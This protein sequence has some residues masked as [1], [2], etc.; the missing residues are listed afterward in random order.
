[1]TSAKMCILRFLINWKKILNCHVIAMNC[2]HYLRT[3]VSC[4]CGLMRATSRGPASTE[5]LHPR[6]IGGEILQR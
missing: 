1:M 2:L 5:T 4:W 3:S 6:E